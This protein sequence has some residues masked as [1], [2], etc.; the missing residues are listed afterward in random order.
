MVT[1][2]LDYM[3]IS[4]HC[5]RNIIRLNRSLTL[6]EKYGEEWIYKYSEH[7]L[8]DNKAISNCV[9][10]FTDEGSMT[11]I[12]WLVDGSSTGPLKTLVNIV[13]SVECSSCNIK[14]NV[15]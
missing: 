1:S 2:Y 11:G 10:I 7:A 8:P 14:I 15:V 6:P 12:A 3:D 4:D 5:P 13:F 9:E